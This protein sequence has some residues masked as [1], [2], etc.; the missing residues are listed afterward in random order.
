MPTPFRISDWRRTV[1]GP[2]H[3]V[4]ADLDGTTVWFEGDAIGGA[5]ESSDPF[6]AVALLAA[7]AQGRDLDLSDSPPISPLLLKRLATL[8]EL[9]TQWNPYLTK[10]EVRADTEAVVRGGDRN[11]TCFS[12]GVDAVHAALDG[13]APGDLLVLI[14]GFDYI[15][16]D[17]AEA[18]AV[19]RCERMAEELNQELTLIRTN[20]VTWRREL[21]L[22]GA[23]MHGG[24]LVATGYLLPLDRLTIASSN[25]WARMTPWGT[26][27][28]ADP[29]WSTERTTI[30]HWGNH[31]TRIEKIARLAGEPRLV[32]DL[33]VCHELPI[34]N[35][36]R[37]SKC[38]RT[39]FGLQL[40]GADLS[41][42]PDAVGVDP[43]AE[44]SRHLRS[45]SEH[46][47]LEEFLEFARERGDHRAER[48]LE[49]ASRKLA[50]SKAV[51]DLAA[52]LMPR[53]AVARYRRS[54]LRPWGHG[55]T[56]SSI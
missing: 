42:I 2:L 10:I 41:V 40:A 21:H 53:W 11:G 17:S 45:G 26:H 47:Y 34:A 35:C 54:D 5:P 56:P 55:P 25:S 52:L 31:R 14:N 23:L 9:W 46:V 43:L 29:L 13:G 49:R 20:W 16:S 44:Y 38:A 28:L 51:R 8:Q 4:A 32:E 6:V 36:G 50:R 27:P 22:S 30:R 12:G 15:M 33:W 18:T 48:H 24:C 7:M 3:R 19:G 37:C 39:R 1:N